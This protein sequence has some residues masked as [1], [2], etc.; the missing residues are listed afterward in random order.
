MNFYKIVRKI[1]NLKT[2]FFYNLTALIYG[3]VF[4]FIFSKY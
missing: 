3:A 4:A 2:D 1:K